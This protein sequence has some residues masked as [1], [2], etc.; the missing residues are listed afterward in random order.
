VLAR[1]GPGFSLLFLAYASTWAAGAPSTRRRPA[2][3]LKLFKSNLW[4]GLILFLAIAAGLLTNRRSVGL[5]R[6]CM[7][8]K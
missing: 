8:Y 7:T 6:S 3:A 4:A 5:T 1:L 2:L